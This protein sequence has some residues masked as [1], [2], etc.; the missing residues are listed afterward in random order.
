M[1]AK[2]M[3]KSALDDT[4][5]KTFLGMERME[6]GRPIVNQ[7]EREGGMFFPPPTNRGGLGREKIANVH[8]SACGK[9]LYF[10]QIN[11]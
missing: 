8:C 11:R 7:K 3:S 4:K 6:H 5:K 2:R 1:S 9:R 10:A